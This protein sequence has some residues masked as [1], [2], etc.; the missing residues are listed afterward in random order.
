M[1][2]LA[3]DFAMVGKGVMRLLEKMP[4]MR[5]T[6]GQVSDLM[7]KPSGRVTVMDSPPCGPLT[8]Y[9]LAYIVLCVRIMVRRM[10]SLFMV[11]RLAD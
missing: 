10:S 3:S 11:Y 1:P 7:S 4:C 2:A 5:I 6:I 9:L 8:S